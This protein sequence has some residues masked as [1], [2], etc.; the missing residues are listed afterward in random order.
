MRLRGSEPFRAVVP[1]RLRSHT[2]SVSGIV[3]RRSRST[4]RDW[5]GSPSGGDDMVFDTKVAIL[6]LDDLA[7]WQ[8][9]NVTASWRRGSRRPRPRR[10]ANPTRTQPAASTP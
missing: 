1:P 10:W 7:V 6:V 3:H 2:G 5:L 4:D 9:L 8:K